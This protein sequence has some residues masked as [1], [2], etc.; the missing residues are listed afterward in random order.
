MPLPPGRDTEADRYNGVGRY[1]AMNH[2]HRGDTLKLDTT[3]QIQEILY[4]F[5]H[6]LLINEQGASL[7][8]ER[9]LSG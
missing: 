4:G 5:H 2:Y 6:A 7:I 3:V 9:D 1:L 8:S